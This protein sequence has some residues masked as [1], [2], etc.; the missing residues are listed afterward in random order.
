MF[1]SQVGQEN[2]R[3]RIKDKKRQYLQFLR[4]PEWRAA[5]RRCRARA[6]VQ[7]LPCGS[8]SDVSVEHTDQ[9]RCC[10]PGQR[11]S[12]AMVFTPI[13]LRISAWN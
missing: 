2:L 5:C 9:T 10:D 4:S 6:D 12:S 7:R 13:V 3:Q 1:I 8:P 11:R